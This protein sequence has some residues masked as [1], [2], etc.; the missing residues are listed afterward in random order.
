MI[1]ITHTELKISISELKNVIKRN[2]YKIESVSIDTLIIDDVMDLRGLFSSIPNI[3]KFY[4]NILSCNGKFI[5]KTLDLTGFISNCPKLKSCCINSITTSN[6]DDIYL[7]LTRLCYRC[8]LLEYCRIGVPNDKT[9]A[10]ITSIN[11]IFYGCKQLSS[12]DLPD[13]KQK[14]P[15]DISNAFSECDT[16][17]RLTLPKY[18]TDNV[19]S[20]HN[21]KSFNNDSQMCDRLI[22]DLNLNNSS[23]LDKLIDNIHYFKNLTI[24]STMLVNSIDI[25]K[26]IE[27]IDN[28]Y[29]IINTIDRDDVLQGK[30]LFT[31]NHLILLP[32]NG[33][34]YSASRILQYFNDNILRINHIQ[35][36]PG[37]KG[38]KEIPKTM[39]LCGMPTSLKSNT[40]WI[41]PR[42]YK[43]YVPATEK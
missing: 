24:N 35:C 37:S 17:Y 41:P 20:I 29:I 25:F 15:I 39:P 34:S 33:N 11:G 38:W 21:L 43:R 10:G 28:L 22:L 14:G 16:L 42:K 30:F 32:G 7:D 26:D 19:K 31:I 12:F 9:F 2:R 3:E 8:K 6:T 23:K 4:I 18:I 27:Y 36:L 1:S 5:A 13:I 40:K